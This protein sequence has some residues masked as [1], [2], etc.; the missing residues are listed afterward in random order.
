MQNLGKTSLYISRDVQRWKEKVTF[1]YKNIAI[2]NSFTV[3]N[4]YLL[5]LKEL[6]ASPEAAVNGIYAGGVQAEDGSFVAGHRR[7]EK[8]NQNLCC[9]KTYELNEEQKRKAVLIEKNIVY[10]GM[11]VNSFGH[12]ITEAFSRLWYILEHGEEEYLLAFVISNGVP[13]YFWD[14]MELLG[15]D[16]K[17][18]LIVNEVM[19]CRTI[20][21]PE[22]AY[23][24]FTGYN[25]KICGVYKRII[26]VAEKLQN[27]VADSQKD[28][29][30]IYLSRMQFNKH[31]CINEEYFTQ[32]YE[33]RGF[34]VVS[35]ETLSVSEQVLLIA[36]ATEIVC[37]AGTLSHLSLFAQEGTKLTILL[38]CNEVGAIVPQ[39]VINQMKRLEVTI[40]DCSYN[41]LPTTHADGIFLM[42]P[43]KDFVNYLDREKIDYKINEVQMDFEKTAWNYILAWINKYGRNG[44]PY[45]RI[46]G[47][48]VFDVVNRMSDVIL[49]KS[50]TR[51]QM[52]TPKKSRI[53]ETEV[54][55]IKTSLEQLIPVAGKYSI[56]NHSYD[57]LRNTISVL[58]DICSINNSE[59]LK[60][61]MDRICLTYDVHISK[62]G[63]KNYNGEYET[64][65]KIH[66]ENKIEAV[67]ARFTEQD[68]KI[69]YGVY[70]E[71]EGWKIENE[72]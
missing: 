15:I 52:V 56:L 21:V 48:D 44:Y 53:S 9:D 32:F 39:F 16:R 8:E 66:S 49:E 37:T 57:C 42:G 61:S 69:S 41:Y 26:T 1:D 31:D 14:F 43:T 68:A 25:P 13:Q 70:V 23:I 22:Q 3:K 24:M 65:G 58:Y 60:E 28:S 55:E 36:A 63:W 27:I 40:M 4:A 19:K 59:E 17:R 35:P 29:L 10:C 51:E 6:P 64:V 18:I 5:P 38:R 62:I 47:Q 34:K 45:K 30:K 12:I 7:Y 67:R 72:K 33:R 2:C 54:K 50:L 46:N 20:I 71:K 11:L